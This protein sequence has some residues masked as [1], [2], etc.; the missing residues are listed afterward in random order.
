MGCKMHASRTVFKCLM[1][2]YINKRKNYHNSNFSYH[3]SL[4][5]E[6]M[7]IY[8]FYF[9]SMKKEKCMQEYKNKHKKSKN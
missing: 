1:K 4:L 3:D 8:M 6:T 9:F 7:A 2:V 5:R